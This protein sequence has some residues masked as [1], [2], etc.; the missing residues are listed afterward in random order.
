VEEL[1]PADRAT[2]L[3]LIAVWPPAD[4]AWVQALE[5]RLLAP[6]PAARARAWRLRRFGLGLAFALGLAALAAGLSLAG[7]GP[8]AGRSGSVSARDDC[9]T[10][11]ITRVEPM[12]TL[13]TG[14]DGKPR[15]VY[16]DGPVTHRVRR[17]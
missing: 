15:L 1:E 3:V 12:P 16:R 10:V 14:A 6:A 2:E 17:C 11:A 7:V 4:P 8:I 5:E 9:R 13:I